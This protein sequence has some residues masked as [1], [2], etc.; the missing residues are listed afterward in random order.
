MAA[1]TW[2]G[3]TLPDEQ[4]APEERTHALGSTDLV[5]RN[6]HKI[7]FQRIDIERN[8]AAALDRVHVQ[9]RA[10]RM[11]QASGLRYRLNNT[12]LVIGKHKRNQRTAAQGGEPGL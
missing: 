6:R 10:R 7:C 9:E 3:W 1:S 4:A 2:E 11:N 12:R 5:S 8:S